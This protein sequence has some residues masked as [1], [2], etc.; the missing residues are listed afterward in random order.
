MVTWY[1]DNGFEIC[2]RNNEINYKGSFNPRN[3]GRDE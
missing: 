2:K 1:A 3:A